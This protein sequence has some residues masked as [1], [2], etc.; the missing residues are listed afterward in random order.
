MRLLLFT[1]AGTSMATGKKILLFL[2]VGERSQAET[3]F[4]YPNPSAETL[5]VKP[6]LGSFSLVLPFGNLE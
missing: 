2:S 1:L 4:V 5:G 6:C 3:P